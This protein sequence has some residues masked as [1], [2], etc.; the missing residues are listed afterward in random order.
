MNIMKFRK[1][2]YIKITIIVLFLFF[3]FQSTAQ[4]N[5]L[6]IGDYY[7]QS[8]AVEALTKFKS[9]YAN[10]KEWE[11]RKQLIIEGILNGS[12]ITKLLDEYKDIPFNAIIHWDSNKMDGYTVEN[13]AIEGI[14]GKYITGNLYRPDSIIGKV[15][16]ILSPHGHWYYPDDYGRFRTDF[17]KRCAAFAKMG[18]IVFAYDMI[19]YGENY[20]FNH[21]DKNALQIQLFNSSRILDYLLSL[22]EVDNKRI[23]MTGASG[24][25]TQ[26]FLLT[27]IDQRITVSAPVVQVSAHFFGGCVCESGMSI[28]KDNKHQTNNV[29]IAATAAPRPLLLVSDGGDWTLNTPDVEYPYIRDVYK[30]YNKENM[31]ENIHLADEVHD[32]GSSKRAAVYKFMVKHLKLNYDAILDK[33][34]F[35]DE[36]SC[37]VLPVYK[38]LVFPERLPNHQLK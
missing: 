18:A 35:I 2:K 15:P 12:E 6:C 22:D 23:G 10:K 9:T 30:L 33:N 38:L 20:Q 4:N 31:V 7:T 25:G 1:Y 3:S 19:G 17:Q 32:Y 8:E 16:A 14:D 37:E 13:I 11:V 34:G 36:N 21:N 29:E 26:T 24:G 5:D 27:A 28:H